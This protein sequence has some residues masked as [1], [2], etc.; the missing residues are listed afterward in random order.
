MAFREERIKKL[1]SRE[2]RL[3]QEEER[4]ASLPRTLYEKA[5][6][7]AGKL[8][9]VQ[10]DEKTRM[11]L[12]DA[13]EFSHLRITPGNVLA[14]TLLFFLF[15][16]LPIVVLTLIK[17]IPFGIGILAILLIMFFAYYLYTFPLHLKKRYEVAA[18]GEIVTMILYMVMYMRESANLEGAVRFA[19]ENVT[20]ELGYELKKLLWDVEVGNY[21][22][23]EE[24]L[25][26]YTNKW[27][28]NRP[29]VEAVELMVTSMKQ[30]ADRRLSLL[31]EAVSIVLQGNREQARHFNQQLKMP[32]MVVH[33]L[34]VVLPVMG[35]VLFPIVAIF[36]QVD[37]MALFIGY[38][39]ILPIILFFVI[40]H[41]L[42]IRPP[43]FS[44]IDISDSPDVPKEGRFRVGKKE[45]IAWPVA[46]LA[47][48][49]VL[50]FGVFLFLLETRAAATVEGILPAMLITF[51]I[52]LGLG[53][54]YI[55]LSKQRLRV[56]EETR[57]VEQEF[58]EA[59]FQLGNQVSGGVPIELS[60]Q[61]AMDRI[62]NLRIR[63]LFQKALNN[64]HSM[65]MTFRQ[66]FFDEQYGAIRYYPSKL[67]KSIMRTVVESTRKGVATAGVAM[68]SVSRYLKN[69]HETQEEV[70]E[71]LSDTLNALRFQAYILSPLISGVI[72]TLAIIII[73]IL[74]QLG[75]NIKSIPSGGPL[76]FIGNFGQ[77]SVSPLQ[78][79]LIVG[80]YL[81]ETSLLLAMFINAIENG[82]D[83][84]GF[85]HAAGNALVIGF[86]VFAIITFITLAIFS[87]L[88]LINL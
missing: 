23:M 13:I 26:D 11:K 24:A 21:L 49:L 1:I 22:S 46:L 5:A 10:P 28:E 60:M 6:R 79:I 78:F 8:L 15:T 76:P 41:I 74:E 70:S 2:Y 72:V 54:Y 81:I 52:A 37:V 3:Y 40:T 83:K 61:H 39:V 16:L 44:R 66:A 84:I 68:L 43:T 9:N 19:S 20:G 51:G 12:Q 53:L 47:G 65:G 85:R 29:F 75:E 45:I 71:S 77:I 59:L 18:G 7:S 50:A 80:I 31:D 73:R 35:L 86:V 88:I 27:K 57:R 82:E 36:L 63:D 14:F 62:K 34:G 25:K 32:V 58:A 48:F 56:R 87:P 4:V 30:G 33:A 17:L 55:L 69:L 67:I 38:D 42:E 64:M